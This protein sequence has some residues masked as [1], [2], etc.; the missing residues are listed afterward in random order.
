MV[1][2]KLRRHPSIAL[3]I[4]G[5]VNDVCSPQALCCALLFFFLPASH[6][7]DAFGL[8][9]WTEGRR[10]SREHTPKNRKRH[11]FHLLNKLSARIS[12]LMGIGN[13]ERTPGAQNRGMGLLI[14]PAPL[15]LCCMAFHLIWPGG[16][17]TADKDTRVSSCP[18]W[19]SNTVCTSK[20][21]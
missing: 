3:M 5:E 11:L 17:S 15:T 9:P 12:H 8:T 1:L 7:S 2:C 14:T 16:T 13:G 18:V 10:I 4:M 19:D 21:F 20:H 6:P